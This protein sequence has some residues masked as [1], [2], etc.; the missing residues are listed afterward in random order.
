MMQT[1]R[2][3]PRFLVALLLTLAAAAAAQ[4]PSQLP[5][6]SGAGPWPGTISVV[7]RGAAFGEPDTATLEV[8]VSASDPDVRRAV[9]SVDEGIAGLLQELIG[10]GVEQRDIRTTSYNVWRE[11]R[12][13]PQGE[14]GEVVF[15]AQHML[16]VEIAGAKRAGEVLAASVEAGA[17]VVGGIT[18]GFADPATLAAEARN[19]AVSDARE[20]AEQLAAAAGVTLGNVVAIEELAGTPGP[21]FATF[22]R[23]TMAAD[24]LAPGELSV[25]IAV[26]M[27]F[28]L[29]D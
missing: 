24:S 8:G 11:E 29:R 16:S 4:P 23:S 5:E 7:G 12:F 2:I 6:T 26:S 25:E 10:L 20:R 17:N 28:R 27:T 14:R 19:A 1:S 15:R 18:F 3:A 22:E 21:V 9:D 13:T